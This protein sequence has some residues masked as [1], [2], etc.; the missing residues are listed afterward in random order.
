VTG[1]TLQVAKSPPKSHK[2]A[3]K[4]AHFVLSVLP[5][6]AGVQNVQNKQKVEASFVKDSEVK[7][8]A[9]FMAIPKRLLKRAVDRNAVKRICREAWRLKNAESAKSAEKSQQGQVKPKLV[10]LV[11]LPT[12]ESTKQLKYLMRADVDVLFA[13]LK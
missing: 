5:S 10:K 2:N 4:S 13:K 9:L 8:K 12:F 1:E 6:P 11:S 7:G 3:L